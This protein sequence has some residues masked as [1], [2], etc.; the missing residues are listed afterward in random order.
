MPSILVVEQEPQYVERISAAL[1]AEGWRVRVVPGVE[2]ALQAAAAEPPDLVMAGTDVP[3]FEVLAFSF[4]RRAGGPGVV[5]LDPGNGAGR[6]RRGGRPARQAVHRPAG[7]ARRPPGPARPAAGGPRAPRRPSRSSPRTTSSA[8]CWPRSRGTAAAP[9][10]AP[11]RAAA[12]AAGP[13]AAPSLPG[14]RTSSAAS[15]RPS[16]ACSAPSPGRGRRRRPR[17]PPRHRRGAAETGR[18]QRRRPAQPDALQPGAG[19][20]EDRRAP[21]GRCLSGPGPPRRRAPSLRR[22]WQRRRHRWPPPARSPAAAGPEGTGVRKA[23]AVGDFDFAELEELARPDPAGHL[24]EPGRP[25][26]PLPRRPLPA[27]PS[28]SRTAAPLR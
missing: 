2:Q 25:A 27:P 8:T 10:I 16:P 1:G 7:G 28:P 11:P 3:G 20:D 14:T 17:R 24:G 4:S 26:P 12:P 18:R 21:T 13:A 19:E 5:A 22:P 15:R 6:G 9:V 23:R